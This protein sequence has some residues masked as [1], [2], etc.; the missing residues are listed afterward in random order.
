[1]NVRK[2]KQA[3]MGTALVIISVAILWL[4]IAVTSSQTI[5]TDETLTSGVSGATIAVKCV[6][7]KDCSSQ[8]VPAL[9]AITDANGKSA[10]AK[11]DAS[12]QFTVK[13]V[14]GIYTASAVDAKDEKRAAPSQQ[15]TVQKDKITR[16][17]FNF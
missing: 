14:P 8:N 11:T 9:I 12:G 10:H 7:D 2:H 1:M 17:T 15:V 16:I 3:Y 5:Q 6:H 13:L 4:L